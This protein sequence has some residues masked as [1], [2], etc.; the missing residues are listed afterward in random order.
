MAKVRFLV[1]GLFLLVTIIEA[2]AQTQVVEFEQNQ[3][4]M[5]YEWLT[6]P[7]NRQEGVMRLRFEALS[8]NTLA[9][10]L[11]QLKVIPWMQMGGGHGHGSRPTI[12][13]KQGDFFIIKKIYFT[14]RGQWQLHFKLMQRPGQADETKTIFY[15]A[16]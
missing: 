14:M 5:H 16:N 13:E 2:M 10:E 4:K 1:V 9:V 11:G 6:T 15:T 12:I 3:L 7:D 8:P